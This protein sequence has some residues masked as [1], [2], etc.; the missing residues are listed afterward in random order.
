MIFKVHMLAYQDEYCVREVDVPDERTGDTDKNRS[1][2]WELGQNMFQN[3]PG[4][5]SVSAGDVMEFEATGFQFAIL[6]EYHL[7]LNMG[8]LVLSHHQFEAYK[9]M[10]QEKRL[11]LLPQTGIEIL[12]FLESE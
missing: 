6:K 8:F 9:V 1:V 2:V 10:S 5:C 11:R 12:S 4:I 7:I 3:V